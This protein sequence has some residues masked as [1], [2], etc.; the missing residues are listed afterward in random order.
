MTHTSIN[1]DELLAPSGFTH[2][3]VPAAGRLVFVAGQTAHQR[4]GTLAG[5]SMRDQFGAAVRNLAT[6]LAAAGATP[7][8]LVAMQIFVTD[9]DEYRA[10]LSAI[11]EHWRARLGSNYPA[12]SLFGVTRL[13]DPA[14]KVELVATAVVPDH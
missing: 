2:V 4:D 12:V 10:S 3:V 7:E 11:G 14:A 1:P 9:V 6:A 13:F 8:H 5:E